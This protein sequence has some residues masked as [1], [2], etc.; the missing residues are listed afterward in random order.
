MVRELHVYGSVVPIHSRNPQ[1]FQHQVIK[2]NILL[3][4]KLKL[5]DMEQCLWKK[6]KELLEK[7]TILSKWL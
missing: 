3:I 5:R 6:Q 4:S 7:S 2:I 1:K